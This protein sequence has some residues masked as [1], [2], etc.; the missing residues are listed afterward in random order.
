MSNKLKVC[1]NSEL[2]L[3]SN[4]TLYL[5][6]IGGEKVGTAENYYSYELNANHVA[7]KGAN[8]KVNPVEFSSLATDPMNPSIKYFYFEQSSN[9]SGRIWFSTC[10]SLISINKLAASQPNPWDGAFFDFVELTINPNENVNCDTTQVVGLGIPITM[11]DPS[12]VTFPLDLNNLSQYTYPKA[13]GITPGLTLSTLQNDFKAY[14]KSI[15]LEDFSGCSTSYS[16]SKSSSPVNWLINPGYLVEK[17]NSS[18]TPTGIATALD[19]AIYE[20]FNYFVTN[21]LTLYFEGE[22]YTA[23]TITNNIDPGNSGQDYTAL[24]FSDSAGNKYPIYYPYFNTNSDSSQG[25]SL[26][27][28]GTLPPPPSFWSSNGLD[29]AIPATGQVLQCEGAFKDSNPN[30]NSAKILSA[31][32]NIVV[33]MLNRGLVPGIIMDNLFTCSGQLT[34]D[35]KPVNIIDKTPKTVSSMNGATLE[36][37]PT[38]IPPHTN[39]NSCEITGN[40]ELAK[41]STESYRQQITTSG[42]KITAGPATLHPKVKHNSQAASNYCTKVAAQFSPQQRVQFAFSYESAVWPNSTT[43]TLVEPISITYTPLVKTAPSASFKTNDATSSV[44]AGMDVFDVNV[45][46]PAKVS[47]VKGNHITIESTI[48]GLLPSPNTDT[49]LFGNFFPV[50]TAGKAKG[51]WNAFASFLHNGGGGTGAPYISNQGYA[52]AYD[53]DGGYSSDI[54]ID[55]PQGQDA[56]IGINLGKLS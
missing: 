46:N 11:V 12:Q 49:M 29:A 4:E 47:K 27:P 18:K 41:S 39:P 1:I 20:F 51:A 55:F 16:K 22:K 2:A 19:N 30:V 48:G 9:F 34:L 50:D 6:L 37:T 3:G 21:T 36:Y 45:Q 26:N 56:S 54:T 43:P 31:L 42:G 25:G 8:N 15:G 44:T 28:N 35:S 52:F 40:I 17:Y 14:V 13:V 5:Y 32:Q 38:G 53:D 33:S 23:K 10:K 7:V 24:E